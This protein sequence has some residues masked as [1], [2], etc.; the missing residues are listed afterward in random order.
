MSRLVRIYYRAFRVLK[1][2]MQRLRFFYNFWGWKVRLKCNMKSWTFGGDVILFFFLL[3]HRRFIRKKI[4]TDARLQRYFS[5]PFF[6]TL[7]RN[8]VSLKIIKIWNVYTGTFGTFLIRFFTRILPHFFMPIFLLFFKSW[9]IHITK[10]N[11]MRKNMKNN[12]IQHGFQFY[13]LF[14]F[15]YLVKKQ[16]FRITELRVDFPSLLNYLKVTQSDYLI[17][18]KFI[19]FLFSSFFFFRSTIPQSME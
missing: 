12:G 8:Y 3:D 7:F 19:F 17:Q 13:Y 18:C 16:L 6:R 2:I 11:N 10:Y 9:T 14:S 4:I 5:F 1:I 15:Q